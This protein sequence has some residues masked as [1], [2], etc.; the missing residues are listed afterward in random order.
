MSTRE[1]YEITKRTGDRPV[2]RATGKRARAY[3]FASYV[4]DHGLD[5]ATAYRRTLRTERGDKKNV[6]KRTDSEI[7]DRAWS[8]W[9]S[10]ECREAVTRLRANQDAIA[11]ASLGQHMWWLNKMRDRA[12]AKGN[13]ELA[14]KAVIKQGEVAGLYKTKIEG[15]VDYIPSGQL[16][17]ELRDLL[18]ANPDLLE[19]MSQEVLDRLQNPQPTV[20][21][22]DF[23]VLDQDS[24]PESVEPD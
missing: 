13:D 14:F 23:E 5:I 11:G 20:D 9:Q 19:G 12:L 10:E 22:I 1:N 2:Q 16:A 21:A 24:L 8:L 4:V 15:T 6:T 3:L 18:N 17:A 7:Y